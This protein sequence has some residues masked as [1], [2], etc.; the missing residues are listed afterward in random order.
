MPF[1]NYIILAVALLFLFPHKIIANQIN[2]PSAGF[3]CSD[4]KS[5]FEFVFDRSKDMDNPTVFRRIKGKFINVGN[6]LAE[7][8]GAY[9]IWEDK[10]FFKTTDFAWTFDKVTSKLSSVVLSV[11]L[12][13]ESLDKIPEP[14]T[15]MQKIFYY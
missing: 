5:K 15:C 4:Y 7:K 11:G 3:D 12:G 9:V 1:K 14:M 6:L 10:E 2:L 13:T 8:Q